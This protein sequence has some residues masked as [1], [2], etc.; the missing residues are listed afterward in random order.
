ME[1]N[2]LK[3]HEDTLS[4]GDRLADGVAETLGSWG[5]IVIQTAFVIA[6]MVLNILA[7]VQQWDPYP[8]ILLNLVF[9]TQAA[10]AAPI[11]MMSQNRQAARDRVQAEQDYQTNIDA[12]KN[13]EEL[14][15]RM[16][17][18]EDQKIDHII[19]LLSTL[20]DENKKK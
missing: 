8:F 1:E 11:I 3:Q 2:V 12:E 4:L 17:R 7:F 10:Y 5:F 14:Q 9:S 16:T 13:I 6:W 15:M 20:V 18:I 19:T